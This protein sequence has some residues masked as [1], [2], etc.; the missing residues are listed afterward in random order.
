MLEITFTK[1]TIQY[2][3][4]NVLMKIEK[5]GKNRKSK[6]KTPSVIRV[7]NINV[8]IHTVVFDFFGLQ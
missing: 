4:I 5:N 2:C 7:Y 8:Y 1:P 3:H 6:K